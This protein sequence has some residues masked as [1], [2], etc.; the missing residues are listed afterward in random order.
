ME[1][2]NL[3]YKDILLLPTGKGTQII[4][5]DTIIRIKAISNYCKLFFTNGS[6]LVVAKVLKWFDEALTEKGFIRIH[7]SHLINTSCITGFKNSR[8]GKIILKND[9]EIDMSRRRKTYF[10]KNF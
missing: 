8:A 9:E 3:P 7:R 2:I 6:T 1:T 5:I 10:L 4:Q